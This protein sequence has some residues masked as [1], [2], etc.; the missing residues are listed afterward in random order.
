MGANLESDILINIHGRQQAG[1]AKVFD[2]QR[3]RLILATSH[4]S[5]YITITSPSTA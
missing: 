3:D 5:T 1:D 4:L 2:I